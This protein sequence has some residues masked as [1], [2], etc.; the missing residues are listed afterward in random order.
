MNVSKWNTNQSRQFS[1][2]KNFK[3]CRLL[4]NNFNI[5]YLPKKVKSNADKVVINL[6]MNASKGAGM[7]ER[8]REYSW[9]R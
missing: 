2:R 5:N 6:V 4:N 8:E 3:Y 9:R 1:D 7:Q